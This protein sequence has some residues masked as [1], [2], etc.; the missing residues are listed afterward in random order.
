MA[1][2]LTALAMVNVPKLFSTRLPP[3]APPPDNPAIVLLKLSPLDSVAPA[4]FASTTALLGENP[5]AILACKL[6]ALM[7]VAP[8]YVLPDPLRYW[9]GELVPVR[10]IVTPPVPVMIAEKAPLL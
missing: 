8:E 10:L 2:P 9:V 1:L 5:F 6:P 7:V 3:V 4:V